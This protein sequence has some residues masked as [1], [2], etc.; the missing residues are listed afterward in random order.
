VE[1]R[2]AADIIQAIGDSLRSDPH[3]F[4]ISV[5]VSGQTIT[6]HG[7]TGLSITASGGGPG[8]TT[9]GQVVSVDGTQIEIAQDKAVQA[10][11][12]QVAALID[13][14]DEI[15]AELRSPSPDKSRIQRIFD[16]LRD[17]WVPGLI[18][19]VLSNA[20]SGAIGL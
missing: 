5:R 16:S 15:A 8:S 19:G 14:L 20:L 2:E 9:V 4:Q 3:Q 17:T 12:D 6:S 18:L 1:P 11:T 10:M 13:S 7:G